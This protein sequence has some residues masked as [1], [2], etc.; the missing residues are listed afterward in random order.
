[1]LTSRSDKV[2]FT[3]V[4]IMIVVL[5]IGI[6]LAI[7]IPNFVQA[8]EVSR[9][10][11]CAAN[12]TQIDSAKQQAAMDHQIAQS[13]ATSFTIAGASPAG[14][15]ELV[16]VSGNTGYLRAIPKCPVSGTYTVGSISVQPSCSIVA[17]N[18]SNPDYQVGGRF[19]H[20]MSR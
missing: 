6:L 15:Y 12:L 5:L 2:G 4:E 16:D 11:S 17:V 3:L 13:S 19:Y 8:R 10:K 14:T 18:T 1:M 20:G 7:E 9:A